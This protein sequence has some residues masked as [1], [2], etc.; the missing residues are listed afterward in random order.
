MFM[1]VL[2]RKSYL[3]LACA[4]GLLLP[5]AN[6]AFAQRLT[7]GSLPSGPPPQP[8]HLGPPPESLPQSAPPDAQPVPASTP[9]QEREQISQEK[10]TFIIGKKLIYVPV[11]VTDKSTGGYV[12]GL[13]TADFRVYD[14]RKPQ[15]I[16]ADL[17]DQPV[18]IVLAIQAN[19]EV[20][21]ILPEL[22]HTGILVQG[23][24]SGKEGDV[25]VL[26][27]D[28]RMLH[29][30][31]GFTSDPNK[32]DDAM[33]KLQAGSTTA[34]VI[35]AVF[36]ADRMLKQHDPNNLRR[37]VILLLSRDVDKGSQANLKEAIYAL[38]FDN[39][40]VY[41]VNI[42]KWLTAV[43]EK[44]GYPRPAYG[45]V[46]AGAMPTVPLHGPRTDT[47]AVQTANGNWLS[48]VPPLFRS[49]RDLFKKTPA[50]AL[51]SFT[52]GRLYGFHNQKGL[53]RAITDI[54]EDVNSQYVLTYAP[55]DL[56]EPG[57]HTIQ[58]V[59]DRPNLSVDARPGYWTAGGKQQ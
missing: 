24:V 56:S 42:A 14:N 58:V 54:G 18:S 21:P 36:E 49:I 48:A 33:Q 45:R 8:G 13:T 38:Q 43:L 1:R 19:S 40:I 32:I 27:F 29:L 53:E 4:V 41:S 52:G 59:V 23:L 39:V 50:E 10:P 55:N 37:R 5:L 26:A 30:T 6:A 44:Q 9:Q 35:D 51:T 11:T 31:K 20:E 17:V 28:H 7:P 15:K 47:Q 12:N 57:F 46:P 2:S 22:R 25:A 34:A 16:Q 3:P